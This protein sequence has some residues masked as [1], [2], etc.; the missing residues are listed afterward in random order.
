M[1]DIKT[2][3]LKQKP[4]APLSWDNVM[5]GSDSLGYIDA[6]HQQLQVYKTKHNLTYYLPL[7]TK[8]P[9]TERK[10]AQNKTHTDWVKLIIDD[11][12][13]VHT[14]IETINRSTLPNSYNNLPSLLKHHL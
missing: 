12:K 11:L 3:E 13:K 1:P 4:G 5:Y 7:C 14:D 2:N 10:L 8:D 9:V 6:T